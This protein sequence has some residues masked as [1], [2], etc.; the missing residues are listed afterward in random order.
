MYGFQKVNTLLY[1]G[2]GMCI[3]F[4]VC[5]G[6]LAAFF[7]LGFYEERVSSFSIASISSS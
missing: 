7:A 1:D 5:L 2:M 4:F 3:S 6:R